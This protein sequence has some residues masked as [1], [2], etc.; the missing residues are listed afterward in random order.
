MID[1]G[2]NLTSSRFDKDRD[3][4]IERAMQANVENIIVTGTNIKESQ[5][6]LELCQQYPKIL[7]CTAGI[8]PHDADQAPLDFID[9]LITLAKHKEVIAI[10]ECGLDFNRNF[11]SP[12]Q[13]VAI[14]KKQIALAKELQLP[15]FLHQRDAFE[16]WLA[17][18]SPFLADIPALISHCF[19]GTLTQ[20]K[21]CIDANMYI[22]ITGW[23]C[24]ERRGTELCSIVN[25][26]PLDRILIETDA[27]YLL[28]RNMRPK[29]KSS[30]NEPS[31]LNFVVIKL[32]KE[33]NITVEELIAHST[34]NAKRA[35]QLTL[36]PENLLNEFING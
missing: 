28:P 2:A 15:L 1:I 7:R 11:S 19:T 27:P 17:C 30:R 8:H 36:T 33:M 23:V 12:D 21:Q 5:A 22:G 14:F 4:V 32:A 13:Q 6:A 35:F 20:L 16:P 10:G 34:D 24:D 18:L 26:I 25:Q 31:F 9:Q 3:A 29:P